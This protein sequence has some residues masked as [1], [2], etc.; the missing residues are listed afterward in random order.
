MTETA[1]PA[2]DVAAKVSGVG[3]VDAEVPAAAVGDARRGAW[4]RFRRDKFACAGLVMLIVIVFAGIFAPLLAPHD[5]RG[6][7]VGQRMSSPSWD[8]LLGTDSLGRDTFSR[9]LFGSRLMARYAVQIVVVAVVLGL[10]LGLAA[11]YRG[12]WVDTVVMRLVDAI[13]SVPGILFILAIAAASQQDVNWVL[14]SISIVFLPSLIRLVRIGALGA[15]EELFVEASHGIGTPTRTILW[16]RVLPNVSSPIIIQSSVFMGATVFVTAALSIL[17][18]GE[19]VGSPSWGAMLHDA[20]TNVYVSPTHIVYPGLAI[21]LTVLSFN[22]VGD[23]LRDAL[24]VD[25]GNLYSS[26]VSLGIT[27]ASVASSARRRTRDRGSV[28][29][30]APLLQIEGLTVEIRLRGDR[31]R[32]VEGVSLALDRGQVLG[33]VGESGAGKTVT[34]M[35]VMRLLPSPP[36]DVTAGRILFEGR[37]LL[38]CSFADMRRIRGKDIAMIFQDPMNSLNPALT[39]GRQIAE[40]VR[41]DEGV[42][43]LIG[44]RRAIE[45]LDRV[46]IPE[47]ARR[48]RHYPHEFSGGMR[49]RVMIAMALSCRPKLL[50]ADEPTTALDVTIQAQIL[51]LLRDITAELDLS[52]LFV[53]HDLGIVADYCDR[54]AVMYAGEVVEESEMEDLFHHPRHPYSRALLASTPRVDASIERFRPIAGQVPPL[55]AMPQGCRF[56]PRCPDATRECASASVQLRQLGGSLVRCIHAD[57]L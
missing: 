23:G 15:R 28:T 31:L 16:R 48:V 45:M 10:P 26:R 49:Q 13:N 24:G 33:L 35:S 19:D 3:G 22:L 44:E 41:H 8:H 2:G 7:F 12:G 18:V 37:D 54:V 36:F 52:V 21:A 32:V 51:E 27:R 5:P 25:R 14:L 34:A 1:P 43:R 9:L 40:S 6:L 50:I 55:S 38:E 39:V 47:A 11:G 46:G 4:R 53:T 56:H 57:D 29:E 30:E 17:G 42:G 20:F